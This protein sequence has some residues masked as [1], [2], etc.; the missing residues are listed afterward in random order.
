MATKRH[1]T[2]TRKKADKRD[3]VREIV[4]E[5]TDLAALVRSY[6]I[7]LA[8]HGGRLWARCPFHEETIASFSVNPAGGHWWCF[9]PCQAGGDVFA[10]VERKDGLGSREALLL[11][12]A[13][14]GVALRE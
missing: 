2:V 12:A 6:G 14:A 1:S 8:E 13:R 5:R 7:D 3:D 9:G 11:L 4:G 10:F